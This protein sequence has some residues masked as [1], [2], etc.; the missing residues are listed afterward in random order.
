MA[1]EPPTKRKCLGADC[2]NDAGTLQCP[3]CLS[4][5]IKDSFFCSQDCFKKNWVRGCVAP[6]LR[7]RTIADRPVCVAQNTHKSMHK[8]DTSILRRVFPPKLASKPDPDTSFFNPFPDFAFTGPLRPVYPLSPKREVPKSIPHPDYA[9]DGIPKSGRILGR[10]NKIE[11]LDT[12]VIEVMRKVCRLA[13]DVLDIAA[14][15]IKPG[16]A[17]GEIDNNVHDTCFERN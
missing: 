4:L 8:Q 15:A 3:K 2:E 11:Q 5:G 13:R 10:T 12:Q 16:I 9:A 14:A 7:L 17:R 1:E 6:P